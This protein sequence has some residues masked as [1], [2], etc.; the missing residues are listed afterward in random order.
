MP[1]KSSSPIF[2]KMKTRKHILLN[3]S[4]GMCFLFLCYWRV[5]YEENEDVLPKRED[6]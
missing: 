4:C 1:L 5:F 2:H 6:I 3:K